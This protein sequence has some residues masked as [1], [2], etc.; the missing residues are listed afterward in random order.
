LDQAINAIYGEEPS[1]TA[2]AIVVNDQI[3]WQTENWDLTADLPGILST[4]TGGG[5]GSINISGVKYIV[6]SAGQDH[7]SATN[8]QGQGHIVGCPCKSG[9]IIAYVSPDGDN[10]GAL[11]ALQ[12]HA[13]EI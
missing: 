1:I 5:G 7:I 3:Y 12:K 11:M 8:I 9:K 4:W 10:R 2:L 13:H 6:L